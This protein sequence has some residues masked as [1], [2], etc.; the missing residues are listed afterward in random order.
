MGHTVGD[1]E[2]EGERGVPFGEIKN[3]FCFGASL[4]SKGTKQ[5]DEASKS[6]FK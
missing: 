6:N 3:Q 2:R 5:E 4:A 1:A